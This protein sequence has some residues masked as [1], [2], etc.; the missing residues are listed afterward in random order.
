M[1]LVCIAQG[2]VRSGGLQEIN[3]IILPA[4]NDNDDISGPGY[5][6][7]QILLAPGFTVEQA[8][9]IFSGILVEVQQREE[10]IDGEVVVVDYWKNK[11][12]GLWYQ[13]KVK[14]NFELS[15]KKLTQ[16]D[17]LSLSAPEISYAIRMEILEKIVSKISDFPN[18]L[19]TLMA[20]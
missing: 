12:D 15:I 4:R 7:T 3:D 14:P 18:N 19:E 9:E 6:D 16:G 1:K 20:E 11:K 8:N 5:A 17:I 2:A 13:L 10:V